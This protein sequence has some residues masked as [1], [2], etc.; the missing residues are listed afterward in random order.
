[1]KYLPGSFRAAAISVTDG[2]PLIA[3]LEGGK[4]PQELNSTERGNA[5]T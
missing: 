1:M 5:L 4:Y 2:K 3:Q